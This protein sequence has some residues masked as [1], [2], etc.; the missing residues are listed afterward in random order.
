MK[1][2]FFDA[3]RAMRDYFKDK[4]FPDAAVDFVTGPADPSA[5]GA[6]EASIISVF[7]NS[8]LDAGILS[9]F[10]NLKFIAARSTGINHIDAEYA[11]EHNIK[12]TNVNGYGEFAVSEFA[13]GLLL[14]LLRK[15]IPAYN[16]MVAGDIEM[17]KYIGRDIHGKTIGVFGTG[18]IGSRFARLA[19]AFGANVIAHD[20]GGNPEIADIVE[21][22]DLETLYKKSD[23]IALNIPANAANYHIINAAAIA[24]MKPGVVLLNV[25]RG[26]LIDSL[27]LFEALVAGH[28]GGVAQ[29]VL[30]LESA[31]NLAAGVDS[32]SRDQM[33]IVMYNERML[34]M[35]NVIFT[36]HT[37]FNSAEANM[38]ILEMTYRNILDFLKRADA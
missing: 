21:F 37:A 28:V 11:R 31:M 13:M 20:R 33:E 16:D 36:P 12:I 32:L 26:E 27:A 15:I 29:D 10:P 14:C 1:I 23:I 38:R 19:H 25:A 24:K 9:K 7:V 5:Q 35:D 4:N 17:G 34:R 18:T 22:V 30:E 8:K 6:A 2:V 3:D